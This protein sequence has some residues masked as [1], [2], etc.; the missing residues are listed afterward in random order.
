MIAV[1]F[2][3]T[4]DSVSATSVIPDAAEDALTGARV[5]KLRAELRSE[6]A[7]LKRTLADVWPR[8]VLAACEGKY[9]VSVDHVQATQ[10][11]TDM[12][13]RLQERRSEIVGALDRIQQ[14][15]Y[16]RCVVCGQQIPYTRLEVVPETRTCVECCH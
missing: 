6:L 12:Y 16:G 5:E 13:D 8:R 2:Y 15:T 3:V 11:A 10:R 9:D 4:A 7:R 14:G 1:V